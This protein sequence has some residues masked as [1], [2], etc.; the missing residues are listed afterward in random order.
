MRA[1]EALSTGDDGSFDPGATGGLRHQE[2]TPSR[3]AAG[4]GNGADPDLFKSALK[5]RSSPRT[6]GIASESK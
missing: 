3:S 5:D 1:D 2:D 4:M 6:A